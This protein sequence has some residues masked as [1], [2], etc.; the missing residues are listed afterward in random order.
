V[1]GVGKDRMSILSQ[2]NFSKLNKEFN[3]S[4]KP[5]RYVVIDNFFNKE[6]ADKLLKTYPVDSAKWYKFRDKIGDVKNVLE[7]GMYGISDAENIPDFWND[8]ILKLNNSTF[9]KVLEKITGVL[10]ILP[11]TYNKIGQWTGLRVMKKGSYQLIH[12]DA[13]LHPHLK[14][15]KKLTIV[16]YLN[17]DWK[18]SDSGYLEIW[19]N[20][21]TEC[22]EKIEPLFN[23]VVLF[24]NTDTSYHGVPEVNG[25]RN[26]FLLSYLKDTDDFKETRPKALF[27][28]RPYEKNEKLIDK[29]ANARANLTDY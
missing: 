15:E 27:V 13:R 19:N 11:D 21:M 7:Q 28:K 8:I 14:L 3:D 16:G 4:K 18:K 6:I 12:S 2:Q 24:E 5:Y 10:N 17:K 1:I 29:I 20:E 25:Y 26:S 22:V 23:R 9:C